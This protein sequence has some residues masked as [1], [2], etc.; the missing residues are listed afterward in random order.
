W[1][2]L[3]YFPSGI[4]LFLRLI[5]CSITAIAAYQ[6]LR[7][8]KS[9]SAILVIAGAAIVSPIITYS[10]MFYPEIPACLLTILALRQFQS[11]QAHATR[12]AICLAVFAGALLWLHPKYLALAVLILLYTQYRLRG[13]ARIINLVLTVLCMGGWFLFLH[14]EYG[15]WSPNRIYGGWDKQTN[16]F[17]VIQGEG[18]ARILIIFRNAA[19]FF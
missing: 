12:S 1:I 2:A 8:V 19:A 18:P 15:S 3:T 14:P 10:G 17:W 13:R 4:V 11:M 9:D 16:L 5:M 6:L 7:L